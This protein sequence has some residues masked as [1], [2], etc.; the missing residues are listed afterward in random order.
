MPLRPPVRVQAALR[1]S[2]PV[3]STPLPA[4]ESNVEVIPPPAPN[5]GLATLF[6]NIET[7][8]IDLASALA[9]V[10]VR[11][12][13]YMLAQQRVLEAMGLRQLA[14]A[15]FLPT[16]NA[17]ANYD[18][19]TG[20]LQQSSGNML[21]VDRNS[22]FVGAGAN[23]LA[24]STT[25]IPGVIWTQNLADVTYGYL[26]SRQAVR[27]RSAGSAAARNE[28]GLQVVS[29][30]LDLLQAEGERAIALRVRR[31]AIELSTLT[32]NHAK[33]GQGRQSDANRA[34]TELVDRDANVLA[35]EGEMLKASARLARLLGLD[36]SL[37]LHPTDNW[38][39]PHPIVPDPIPLEELLIIALTQ[40]PEL[41]EQQALVRQAMLQLEGARMLPFSP[42]VFLG[43]SSGSF[44]G[45][46]NLVNAPPGSNPFALGNPSY[47]LFSTRTDF[48]AIAFWTLKNVGFG[49]RALID[50][51]RARLSSND[52]QRVYVYEQ[53]RMEVANSHARTR[54]RLAQIELSEEAVQA[55]TNSWVEDMNRIRALE[56]LPI[57]AMDSLRLLAKA[58][59][60]YLKS[61]V[62]YNRSQFALY[63]ALGQPPADVLVRPADVPPQPPAQPNP[64]P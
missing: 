63:V 9:L 22:F 32:A 47:G 4:G 30:Y 50:A 45:G 34:A 5:D 44:G 1:Q 56:G 10:D 64:Q 13:Q 17:G 40:R 15:Q 16:L 29:A 46:S 25:N 55:A 48:D 57:E 31:E 8:P 3:Q 19:H 26:A 62:E 33:T 51:V 24:A 11:N 37:R 41:Q 20:N 49:N 6:P 21:S 7:P 39:V 59:T 58:R 60:T 2:D 12:P 14:A 36:P 38:V 18:D 35:A 52:W 28:I 43:Y 42:T 23:A 61:I 54:A 53:I 27:A